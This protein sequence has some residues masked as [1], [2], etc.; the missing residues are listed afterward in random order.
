[1]LPTHKFRKI[2]LRQGELLKIGRSHCSL[3]VI[4]IGCI[5]VCVSVQQECKEKENTTG[6]LKT[7]KYFRYAPGIIDGK[8][9]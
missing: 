2:I 9:A 4:I 3:Q 1:M 6:K 7:S 5:S 8:E